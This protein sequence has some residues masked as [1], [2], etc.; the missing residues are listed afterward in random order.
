MSR[1][2]ADRLAIVVTVE[3]GGSRVPAR[4]RPLFAGHDAVLRGHRGRDPGALVMGRELAARFRAPLI[5][6]TTTRLLVDLNR[7]PGHPR[8]F[9]EFTLPLPQPE[10]ERVFAQHWRPY[11]DEVERRIAGWVR[12]GR[13][14]LHV[15]SH[16]FTPML[17]GEVRT[18]DIGLLYD[19]RR[20]AERA[21]ARRWRE[22]LRDLDPRLRIRMNY[23]YAGRA[24][25]LTRD[26]RHRFPA[27]RYLGLEIEVNQRFASTGGRAWAALRRTVLAS[28]EVALR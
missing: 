2:N 5:A 11:R 26:L 15:S 24:D 7:S 10:R 18:A 12:K 28:L 22:A 16:S 13:R 9:S 27:G 20:T 6:S 21:F 3:H 4:Y 8:L 19:P 14:V 23:P 17:D 1:R 25:G